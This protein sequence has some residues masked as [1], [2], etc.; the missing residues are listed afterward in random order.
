MA[1]KDTHAY[2]RDLLKGKGERSAEE[3]AMFTEYGIS[4]GDMSKMNHFLDSVEDWS[5]E[6]DVKPA[7]S[8]KSDLLSL[9]EKE[10]KKGAFIWLNGFVAWM[11]P[12]DRSL[13]RSP[14]MQMAMVGACALLLLLTVNLIPESEEHDK[15]SQNTTGVTKVKTKDET[16]PVQRELEKEEVKDEEL[17]ESEKTIADRNVITDIESPEIVNLSNEMVDEQLAKDD[18]IIVSE[19][20]T[21]S[22][23]AFS[24]FD[25]LLDGSGGS[26]SHFTFSA[27]TT[28][29]TGSVPPDGYIYTDSASAGLF[30]ESDKSK[31]EVLL[32]DVDEVVVTNSV[33]AA[34]V[35][36]R[37]QVKDRRR[38]L[39]KLE[40]SVAEN[41][42]LGDQKYGDTNASGKTVDREIKAS[43]KTVTLD[44]SG[45]D[46]LDIL[47]TAF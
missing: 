27:P 30:V 47:Y 13:M 39:D 44:K 4:E 40:T 36:K 33:S 3:Q 22:V 20:L 2:E 16:I 26:T 25:V 11:F 34:E 21:E 31:E 37:Y 1:R 28:T 29:T 10:R 41:R 5:Q 38:A 45:M 43:K 24:D 42:S 9:F 46:L 7:P 12:K 18:E 17:S 35:A 15:V 32:D 19:E 8:V 6:A 23:D 14:G